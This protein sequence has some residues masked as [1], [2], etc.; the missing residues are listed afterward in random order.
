[1]R[2]VIVIKFFIKFLENIVG[3]CLFSVDFGHVEI[4]IVRILLMNDGKQVK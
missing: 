1:M 3:K 4:V 2:T